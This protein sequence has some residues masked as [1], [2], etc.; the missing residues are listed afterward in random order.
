MAAAMAGSMT[1]WTP[2]ETGMLAAGLHAE[3]GMAASLTELVSL[4]ICPDH[5]GDFLP[6][7]AVI[8]RHSYL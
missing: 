2:R 1:D 4:D 7:S 8:N 6:A 3:T 5:V